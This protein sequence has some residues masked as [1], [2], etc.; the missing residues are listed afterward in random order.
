MV[1]VTMTKPVQHDVNKKE[2][3]GSKERGDDRHSRHKES[4]R[5]IEKLRQV[6]NMSEVLT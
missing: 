6:N 5:M 2:I 4:M 1:T 3:G